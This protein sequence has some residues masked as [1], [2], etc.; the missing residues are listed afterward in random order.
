MGK[1]IGSHYQD[2]YLIKSGIFIFEL[3][4]TT[5]VSKTIITDALINASKK[6]SIPLKI[7]HKKIKGI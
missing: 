3:F 4:Y 5:F 6:F 2:I 1:G 7:E